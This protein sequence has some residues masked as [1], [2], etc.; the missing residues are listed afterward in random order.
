MLSLL[1]HQFRHAARQ[2]AANPGFSLF[3][4][5]SLAI[6]IGASITL[7]SVAETLL[8]A[9]LRGVGAP[10]DLVELSSVSPTRTSDAFSAPDFADYETR[11]ADVANVFAWRHQWMNVDVAGKPERAFGL[12]VSGNYFGALEVGAFRGRLL[13]RDDD[14]EG[15]APVAVATYAGWRK[16]LDGDEAAI[17]KTVSINGQSFTLVGV[18]APDFRGTVAVLTPAF[19][20]PLAQQPRLQP[21][22]ADL[23]SQRG[24]AWLSLGA[25]LLPG[26][27]RALAR[28]RLSSI[29]RPKHSG[30]RPARSPR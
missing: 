2:L 10:D 11:A 1:A 18:A 3:A 12:I 29:D 26:T 13:A 17:G 22:A 25:R 23:R 16:Y 5:L 8:F 6:G 30:A 24:S 28:E 20:V 7:F 21:G 9:P 19:Y 4:A 27:T 14:R 15:A